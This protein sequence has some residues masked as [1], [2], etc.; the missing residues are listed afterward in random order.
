M[1]DAYDPLSYENLTRSIVTALLE[2]NINP[3]PPPETFPG[4]GVYAIY[5]H[6][7]LDF[8]RAI[9]SEDHLKP[10]YVG[11]AIPPGAR[12]GTSSQGVVETTALHRRLTEHAKSV[13]QAENLIPDDFACRYLAVMPVWISLAERF[14]INHFRPV[15]NVLLDGFGNHPPG[16][17]RKDM[18]RPRWDIVH[19]GRT[20]AQELA[21][22]ETG[23]QLI[24][25]ISDAH[26]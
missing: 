2:S 13:L 18:R 4:A 26:A 19:P 14:L 6:G 16:R 17:G 15:W 8:Y 3:L 1:S 25:M 10:I 23:E 22:S 24:R 5:Y 21:A 7:D 9:A 20:W 12:K 11:K